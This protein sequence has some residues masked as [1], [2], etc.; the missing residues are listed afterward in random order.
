VPAFIATLGVMQVA[1][2]A[3]FKISAG[4]SINAVPPSFNWLG[5]QATA[6]LP[7]AVWLAFAVTLVAHVVM[8]QTVLG[9]HIYAAGSNP[10]AARFSGISLT[11]VRLVVFAACGALAG[12]GGVI[13]AS[14]FTSGSPTY[15]QW[16]ELDAI[17]A[18]VVGGTSLE[19]GRGTIFG[20]LVGALII[21]VIRNGMNLI[22][23]DPYMQ[24]VW[25]GLVI[26]AAVLLDRSN[27]QHQRA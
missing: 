6:G 22:G 7:H 2:G 16:A 11:R 8:S 23:I 12:L 24:K 21:A 15:G 10:E 13:V 19:G 20:T 14:Q 26:L 1:S 3:A 5:L 17:A 27:R 4:E 9:R 18:A 25:L